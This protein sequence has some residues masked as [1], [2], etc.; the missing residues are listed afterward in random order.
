MNTIRRSVVWENDQIIRE[1]LQETS[2]E[3]L[4]L[5]RIA[6]PIMHSMANIAR[7]AAFYHPLKFCP[8]FMNH[9]VF[10]G[11]SHLSDDP[12]RAVVLDCRPEF[13]AVGYRRLAAD[14]RSQTADGR[15]NKKEASADRIGYCNIPPSRLA[16]GRCNVCASL[17]SLQG[18]QHPPIIFSIYI[19][20]RFFSKTLNLYLIFLLN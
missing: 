18:V 2:N 8:S 3:I 1:I 13:H 10:T 5:V 15:W 6:F 7:I 9:P 11:V 12:R 14:V 17:G 19:G 16:R 4:Y 20:F